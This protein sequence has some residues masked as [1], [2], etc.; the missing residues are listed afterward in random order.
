MTSTAVK[1]EPQIAIPPE[2]ERIEALRAI[3]GPYETSM[4]AFPEAIRELEQLGY[5]LAR[6]GTAREIRLN[7]M[8]A[9]LARRSRGA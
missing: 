3:M 1:A 4:R 6:R 2:R 9:A 5:E 7:G 8:S